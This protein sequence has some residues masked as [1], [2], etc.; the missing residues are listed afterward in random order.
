MARNPNKIDYSGGFPANFDTFSTIT[1]PRDGGHSLHHFGEILSI[2]FAG[3]LCGVRSYELMAESAHLRED[4]LRKWLQPSNG[5]PSYN[6]FSHVLQAIEP[7]ISATCIATR[8]GKLG[9]NIRS[10][11]YSPTARLRMLEHRQR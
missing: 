4:W 1:A 8:L 6:T 7:T 2:A 3:L 10:N 9:L 5:F 11:I